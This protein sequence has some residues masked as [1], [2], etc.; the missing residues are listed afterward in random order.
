MNLFV[1][2]HSLTDFDENYDN[3][4]YG[5]FRDLHDRLQGHVDEIEDCF[6]MAF[7]V[8]TAIEAGGLLMLPK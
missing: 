6:F 4:R 3:P 7:R 8:L 1:D 2:A 5:I